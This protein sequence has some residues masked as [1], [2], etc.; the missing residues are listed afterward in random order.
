VRYLLVMMLRDGEDLVDHSDFVVPQ[1]ERRFIILEGSLA[2]TE[3]I[4]GRK[5]N[6]PM[7]L[8]SDPSS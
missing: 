6:G 5:W 1:M 8:S 4:N 2:A 7:T 3:Y